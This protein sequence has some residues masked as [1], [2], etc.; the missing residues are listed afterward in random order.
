MVRH[1]PAIQACHVLDAGVYGSKI[2]TVRD[3]PGGYM[4]TGRRDSEMPG[5]DQ[6]SSNPNPK[7]SPNPIPNLS[8]HPH[9]QP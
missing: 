6:L 5:N 4:S 9:P 3:L 8:S 2:D 1:W 7:L